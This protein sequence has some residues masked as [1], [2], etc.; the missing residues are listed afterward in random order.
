M[1]KAQLITALADI[2]DSAEIVIS[3]K[4]DTAFHSV[5]VVKD[6]HQRQA[7]LESDENMNMDGMFE[8]AEAILEEGSL[9]G[10]EKSRLEEFLS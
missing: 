8:M 9:L 3:Y 2:P 10:P 5:A 1:T 4:D 6:L 7:L